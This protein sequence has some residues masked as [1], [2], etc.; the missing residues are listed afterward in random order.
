MQEE[1]LLQRGELRRSMLMRRRQ[2]SVVQR[3]GMERDLHQRL[4]CLQVVQDAEF[5]FIYCAYGSEVSTLELIDHL[6]AQ[7]KTICVPLCEPTS[8]TLRA[9]R[10]ID[11]HKELL[12]GYKGIPEPDP[13]LVE[14]R[15]TPAT[16]LQVAIIPGSVFDRRGFRLGYGGGYYDRFL[17]LEAPQALR[18][19][20]AFDVQ[21]VD[22]LPE[23]PHD[24]PMDLLVTERESLSW[25]RPTAAAPPGH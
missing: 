10:I 11:P 22:H 1:V 13:Q 17:A 6:L 15:S 25:L 5:F 18:I 21:L 16:R 14:E 20:L 4:R 3:E 9:V 24:V 8:T 12:P 19:G 2:L 23:E 7:G